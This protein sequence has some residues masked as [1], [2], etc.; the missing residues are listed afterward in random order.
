V[1]VFKTKNKVIT[2]GKLQVRLGVIV[3]A[4]VIPV[5]ASADVYRIK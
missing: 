1:K 2:R 4:G 5:A 3:L